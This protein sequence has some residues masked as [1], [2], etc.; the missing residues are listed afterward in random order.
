MHLEELRRNYAARSLDR[1]DLNADPFTQ[2]DHW[3]REAIETQVLEPNAM[4]LATTD[5]AGGPAQR[6]RV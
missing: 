4:A 5:A 3:M 6:A 1:D 2:F